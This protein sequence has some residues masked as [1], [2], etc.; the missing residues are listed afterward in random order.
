MGASMTQISD[1]CNKIVEAVS[2]VSEANICFSTPFHAGT[3]TSALA[4]K[5][6]ETSQAIFQ[7]VTNCR[8]S[9]KNV[10][11]YTNDKLWD[12]TTEYSGEPGPVLPTCERGNKIMWASLRDGIC[13][14]LRLPSATNRR[15]NE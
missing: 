1:S 13:K 5:V 8:K 6:E 4:D 3:D 10:F 9:N 14:T 12:F 7:F 2:A 11:S 15:S